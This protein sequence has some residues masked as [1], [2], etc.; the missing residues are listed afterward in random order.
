MGWGS[1]SEL[2][3]DIMYA[4]SKEKVSKRQQRAIYKILIPVFEQHDCDT[5]EECCDDE[6]F[7]A[8]YEELNPPEEE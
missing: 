7:K 6:D 4:L 5:L 2:M 3:G 1:G 8:V